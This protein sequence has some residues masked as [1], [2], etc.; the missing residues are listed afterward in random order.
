M[1]GCSAAQRS[2]HVVAANGMT[3]S[4]LPITICL[5][6]ANL[7]QHIQVWPCPHLTLRKSTTQGRIWGRKGRKTKIR[8]LT[9]TATLGANRERDQL[10]FIRG[11]RQEIFTEVVQVTHLSQ[12]QTTY[13]QHPR[14]LDR[15]L[16]HMPP[17][18]ASHSC[19]ITPQKSKNYE[20]NLHS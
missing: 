15:D 10:G 16:C 19:L 4:L 3:T 20:K 5:L 17:L 2:I 7:S 6:C 13:L 9:K 14:N 1:C 11:Q 18:S 12:V 8:T